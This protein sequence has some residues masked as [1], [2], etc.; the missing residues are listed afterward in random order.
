MGVHVGEVYCFWDLGRG[1][2][3]NSDDEKTDDEKTDDEIRGDWNYIGDGINGGNRVLSAIGKGTDD[4]LFISGAVRKKLMDSPFTNDKK[5]LIDNLHNRGR[6]KDKHG[7]PWRVYEVNHTAAKWARIP[8]VLSD[9][10][11]K[12]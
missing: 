5:D 10:S 6:R 4:V 9:R 1:Q 8:D 2:Q 12:C 7:K 3:R 11:D